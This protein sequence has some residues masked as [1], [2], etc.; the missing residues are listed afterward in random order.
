MNSFE[1]CK[2]VT[3]LIYTPNQNVMTSS[4]VTDCFES[5]GDLMD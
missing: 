4:H 2:F 1:T 3:Y 5:S